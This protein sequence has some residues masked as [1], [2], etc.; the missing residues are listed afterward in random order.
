MKSK[1]SLVVISV[2]LSIFLAGCSKK[3][4]SNTNANSNSSVTANSN[5]TVAPLEET[6]IEETADDSS[7]T[8]SKTKGTGKNA[9]EDKSAN[10]NTTTKR[11]PAKEPPVKSTEKVIRK[12]GD[13][14]LRD[15]G[16]LIKEGERQ[17]RG[18]LNGRP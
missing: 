15:A 11:S 9:R 6:R 16:G 18:V 10:S 1:L 4:S 2:L 8:T 3:S 12:Q 7:T 13:R 14:A 5:A 17:I